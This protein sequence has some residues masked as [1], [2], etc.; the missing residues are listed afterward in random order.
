MVVAKNGPFVEVDKDRI[1]RRTAVNNFS[2]TMT[3][4]GRFL[5]IKGVLILLLLIGRQQTI[6]IP[7]KRTQH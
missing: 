4:V 1:E 6:W 7:E 3:V 5:N 2:T